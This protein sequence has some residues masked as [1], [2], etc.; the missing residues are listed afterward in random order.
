MKVIPEIYDRIGIV[1]RE[2]LAERGTGATFISSEVYPLYVQR[3]PEDEEIMEKLTNAS[4]KMY[5]PGMV[6]E[7]SRKKYDRDPDKPAI[8]FLGK[9]TYRF[10]SDLITDNSLYKEGAP[11]PL[12]LSGDY[13]PSKDDFESVYRMLCSPGQKIDKESILDQIEKNAINSGFNLKDNWRL[14]TELN[15]NI[16]VNDK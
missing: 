14:I 13:I 8:E 3:Y 10:A 11:I 4:L 5:V 15:I 6:W 9:K 12:R 1:L 2:M 7:Y 16:W